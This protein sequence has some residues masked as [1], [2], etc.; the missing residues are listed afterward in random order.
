MTGGVR[1]A[2]AERLRSIRPRNLP[3]AC[4][5]PP[6]RTPSAR[7][8]AYGAPRPAGAAHVR[9]QSVTVPELL[10]RDFDASV[11]ID[12]NEVR[13]RPDPDPPFPGQPEPACHVLRNKPRNQRRRIQI[14]G[15]ERAKGRLHAADP[16]PGGK[17]IRCLLHFREETGEWSEPIVS[18]LPGMP[19]RR[20]ASV[21]PPAERSGGAHFARAPRPPCRPLASRR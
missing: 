18:T 16:S 19:P 5:S 9:A 8:P 6:S 14:E 15:E 2:P 20:R 1:P 4:R 12:Q 17:E 21:A 10:S 3:A 11:Q 7:A 13:V